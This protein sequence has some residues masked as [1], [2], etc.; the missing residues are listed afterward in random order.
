MLLH[1][2][3]S[4]GCRDSP[5]LAP[6][7]FLPDRSTRGGT[8]SSCRLDA[9]RRPAPTTTSLNDIWAD[10]PARV[11]LSRH[12]RARV[13]QGFQTHLSGKTQDG[14]VR[15]R[16]VGF[17]PAPPVDPA[18]SAP[19]RCVCKPWTE[20]PP[21]TSDV[22]RHADGICRQ[23]PRWTMPPQTPSPRG[24]HVRTGCARQSAAAGITV[25]KSRGSLETAV[26]TALVEHR[27]S[28]LRYLCRRLGTAEDAEDALQD[29]C[30][31]ALQSSDQLADC[32]RMGAWLQRVLR[33]TLVD[34]Y[35]RGASRNRMLMELAAV[36]TEVTHE[37]EVLE[38]ECVNMCLP[39]LKPEFADLLRRADLLGQSHAAIARDLG[40]SVGN[41][42]VRLHRA[43]KGLR[44]KLLSR[45]EM[46]PT[47]SCLPRRRD[48]P[49]RPSAANGKGRPR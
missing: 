47:G 16:G 22:P 3:V 9:D 44:E 21:T 41:V 12:R 28:F 18:A 40:L 34:R 14:Q 36:A 17:K 8:H 19:L 13:H 43:R 30:V 20:A 31:R 2:P 27:A 24:P 1:Y 26:R 35:R 42:A 46:C 37:Q 49:S 10:M 7:L 4:C 15:R 33:S 6:G 23:P 39:T 29:F 38:C 48:R 5:G 32:A 11:R 25:R 45:S